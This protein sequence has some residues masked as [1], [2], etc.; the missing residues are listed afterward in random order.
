[1]TEYTVFFASFAGTIVGVI[2]LT[3]WES[4]VR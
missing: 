4:L 2:V 1:M 3:A